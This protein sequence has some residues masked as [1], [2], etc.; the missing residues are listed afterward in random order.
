MS[1]GTQ[2]RS[3]PRYQSEE[4]KILNTSFSRVGIEPTTVLLTVARLYP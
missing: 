3:L 1:G 4:I 2:R